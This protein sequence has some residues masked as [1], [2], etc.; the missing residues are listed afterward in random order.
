[1]GN[2]FG[3]DSGLSFFSK[4]Q[5]Q[6]MIDEKIAFFITSLELKPARSEDFGPQWVL[7]LHLC[8]DLQSEGMLSFSAMSDEKRAR[9]PE[10]FPSRDEIFEKVR[11]EIL[12]T[13][14]PYGLC[15]LYQ[16][17]K[18][19]NGKQAFVGIRDVKD[20]PQPVRQMKMVTDNEDPF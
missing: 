1:M 4:E 5:K 6:Q 2:L 17:K 9:M 14:E 11:D 19:S 3:S 8:D 20:V 12:E 10:G 13:G 15:V 16:G 7:S 18:P